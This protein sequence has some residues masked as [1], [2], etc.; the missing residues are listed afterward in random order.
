MPTHL[1]PLP[2]CCSGVRVQLFDKLSGLISPLGTKE[3]PATCCQDIYSCNAES[4]KAG[5]Y[6]IDPNEGSPKDAIRVYCKGAET[7]LTPTNEVSVISLN[8]SDVLKFPESVG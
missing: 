2:L 3:N 6:W 7:C 5:Y 4:F 8:Q 1:F